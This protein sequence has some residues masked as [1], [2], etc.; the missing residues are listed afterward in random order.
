MVCAEKS[1]RLFAQS[2]LALRGQ[3]RGCLRFQPKQDRYCSR[4]SPERMDRDV[5]VDNAC[6]D[7]RSRIVLRWE[8]TQNDF[9]ERG[10][11]V[12]E[13]CPAPSSE[14]SRTYVV[15]LPVDVLGVPNIVDALKRIAAKHVRS[16]GIRKVLP[17][18]ER[19]KLSQK[20]AGGRP[21]HS[22]SI[23]SGGKQSREEADQHGVQ[24]CY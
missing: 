22:F 13:E 17:L 1:V 7:H 14:C 6:R 15:P 19:P 10:R 24:G 21:K 20:S 9:E 5:R 23:P 18:T 2:V 11:P 12:V 4:G 16:G 3:L 8:R